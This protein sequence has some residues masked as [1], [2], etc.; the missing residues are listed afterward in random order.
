GNSSA[1][2]SNPHDADNTYSL[3]TGEVPPNDTDGTAYSDFLP[4]LIGGAP[5]PNGGNNCCF[6]GYCDWRLPASTDYK[7]FL[8]GGSV[9]KTPCPQTP[10]VN[11][12]F[13][14]LAS[15][16]VYWSTTSDSTGR[17]AI[18]FNLTD[19]SVSPDA[20]SSLHGIRAVRAAERAQPLLCG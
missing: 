20:R 1:D 8:L 14:P 15:P 12:S 16:P 4:K 17:F 9:L 18:E 7:G 5:C 11:T 3:G 6:A 2:L 10:C 13:L 19:G